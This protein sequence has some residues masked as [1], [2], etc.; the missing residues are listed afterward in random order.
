MRPSRW[1]LPLLGLAITL[2]SFLLFAFGLGSPFV[3]SAALGFAAV[4]L[5]GA[6]VAVLGAVRARSKAS[7][8]IAVLAV[9]LALLHGASVTVFARL[10]A[11]GAV[12]A[13]GAPL[14]A[15]ALRDADGKDLALAEIGS[16]R[17]VVLFR[18]V[19]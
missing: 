10:P 5:S 16:P 13:L 2:A 7:G 8:A 9:L 4:G 6:L 14:P 3:R 11:P 15:I 19:W 17:I 18:G 12:P 1:R